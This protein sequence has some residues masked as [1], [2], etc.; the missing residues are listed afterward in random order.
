M[1]SKKSLKLTIDTDTQPELQFKYKGK[2]TFD[3]SDRELRTKSTA[4]INQVK[5][6]YNKNKDVSMITWDDKAEVY[7][8]IKNYGI[9]KMSGGQ[10]VLT[11][12]K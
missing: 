2:G 9:G 11:G 1:N 8:T 6:Y 5:D 7:L 12:E 10:F 3:L 4:I